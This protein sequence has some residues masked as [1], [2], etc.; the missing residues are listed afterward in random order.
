MSLFQQVRTTLSIEHDVVRLLVV[1]NG[2]ITTWG[3]APL[4]VGAVQDGRIDDVDAVGAS[5]AALAQKY[6]PPTRDV[7]V[8]LPPGE[9][10]TRLV[11]LQPET[12][13]NEESVHRMASGFWAVDTSVIGWEELQ[14]NGQRKLFLLRV[15]REMIDNLVAALNIGGWQPAAVEPKPLALMRAAGAPRCIITDIERRTLT[16]TLANHSLP[17]IVTTW[18]LTAPLFAVP[19]AKLTRFADALSETLLRYWQS[20]QDA[21]VDVAELS[22]F[23]AGTYGAHPFLYSVLETVF[24]YEVVV[25]EVFFE[26]PADLPVHQYMAN[27]GLARKRDV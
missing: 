12:T 11:T 15:H 21:A 2:R 23:C 18:P 1:E 27:L 9:S 3:S 16:I 4:P 17:A 24:G 8:A 25:P 26:M 13:V 14:Q 19:E 5:L 22:V 20:E 10:S 6:E 7:Y